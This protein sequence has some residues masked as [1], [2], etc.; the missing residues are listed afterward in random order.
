MRKM[1]D[2]NNDYEG[3]PPLDTAAA[4]KFTGLAVATLAKL[5]CIGGGPAYLKLGRKVVYR[6]GD[7]AFWLGARRVYNT[8]EASIHLPR[9]LSDA[10]GDRPSQRQ[11]FGRYEGGEQ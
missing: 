10:T 11:R 9:R 6:A 4:A 5:R 7:V 1:T 2:S 3:D 8:S